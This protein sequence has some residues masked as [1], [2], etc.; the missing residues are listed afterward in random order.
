MTNK[1]Y[2][3]IIKCAGTQVKLDDAMTQTDETYDVQIKKKH[4]NPGGD[5]PSGTNQA[6]G[7]NVSPALARGN[8]PHPCAKH[9]VEQN[10][11]R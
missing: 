6:A 2:A 3:S 4:K 5:A 10:C 1:N 11:R 8:P 9:S 7:G